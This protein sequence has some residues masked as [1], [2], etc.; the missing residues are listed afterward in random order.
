[1]DN[2]I[3]VIIPAYDAEKYIE[4]CLDSIFSQTYFENNNYD[5]VIGI[6]GCKKTLCKINNIKHKYFNVHVLYMEKNMGLFV[7]LNTLFSYVKNNNLSKNIIKFDSDDI[8][9]PNMIE[10]I[11]KIGKKYDIVRF[12]SDNFYDSVEP[13]VYTKSIYPPDGVS[14]MKYSVYDLLG[15][16]KDWICGADSD[17]LSRLPNDTKIKIMNDVLFYRRF[18]DN[19]L[20]RNPETGKGS[21]L[22]ESYAKQLKKRISKNNT[23]N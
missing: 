10:K 1:M 5:I 17:F 22:R 2:N 4:E 8:M 11:M 16:Y 7:T 6:D 13:R 9:K 23:G 3:T 15:G 19:S 14:F 18:H 20:T 21:K 12:Y